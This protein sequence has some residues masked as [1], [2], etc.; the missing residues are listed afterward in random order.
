[1]SCPAAFGF[2]P[3]ENA[4]HLGRVVIFQNREDLIE[5]LNR[6]QQRL[7]VVFLELSRV[8][9][10]I[11]GANHIEDGSL[12]LRGIEVIIHA[13]RHFLDGLTRQFGHG[14]IRAFGKVSGRESQT[15][16]AQAVDRGCGL[17]KSIKGKVQLVAI[18]NRGQQKT[19]RGRLVP[20]KHQVTQGEEVAQA[21]RHL[22]A[23]DQQEARMKPEVREGFS[24]KRFRLRD[25]VLVM[26][27]DQIFSAGMQI[28]GFAQLLHR[29]DGALDM[30]SRASRADRGIP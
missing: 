23:F 9:G 30:P 19:D 16:V 21:L 1:M 26:R 14:S 10:G 8:D 5:L 6:V 7:R 3:V 2:G 22:L 17:L 11:G 12:R 4:L 24:G 25:F 27:E 28:E 20:L 13:C 29:H 15:E 18:G